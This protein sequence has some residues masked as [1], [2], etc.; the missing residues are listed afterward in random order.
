MV[1]RYPARALTGDYLRAGAGLAVGLGV[2]L[3]TTL[4]PAIVVIVGSWSALFGLFAFR[5]VQ[6]NV[7]KVAV[8]DTELCDVGLRTRV[9]AW[10]DLHR[11]KL[12]YF[13]TKKQERSQGGF[14]QRSE[15]LI[16]A[17]KGGFSFPGLTKLLFKD[18]DPPDQLCQSHVFFSVIQ[19]CLIFPL[20]RRTFGMS[21][22]E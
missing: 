13:G 20:E 10:A 21:I 12:R 17:A 5:T 7:T 16:L 11:L 8:T 6:R 1:Y 18:L 9:L 2:L 15:I 19:Q 3:S 22:V 4:S 14:M